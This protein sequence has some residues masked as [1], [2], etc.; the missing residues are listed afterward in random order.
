MEHE[1]PS[2]PPSGLSRRDLLT[3]S[4]AAVTLGGAPKSLAAPI[5]FDRSAKSAASLASD[6]AYWRSVARFYDRTE[7][8]VNLEQG[9]WAK[10][11]NPV[12]DT[13]F[14][15]LEMVNTQTSLY[16]RKDYNADMDKAVMAVADGLGAKPSEIAITENATESFHNLM[17]QY[18]GFEPGDGVLMA[19]IDYPAFKRF[20]RWQAVQNKGPLIEVIIPERANQDEVFQQYLNAFYA[21]PSLKL[22]LVTHVSNQHGL[23]VPVARIATEARKRGITVICDA[24]QSWGLLDFSISD[25]GVDFAAFNLHKWIGAPLGLGALYISESAID[26]IAPFHGDAP[27]ESRSIRARVHPATRNFAATLAIPKAFEF[28]EAVGPA[29][30]EARLKYLRNLWVAEARSMSHIELLGGTNP[31]SITGISSFRIRGKKTVSDAVSLQKRLE[32]EFGVFTVMRDGLNGGACVRITPQVFNTPNDI[33]VLVSAMG[34][35]A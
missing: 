16:A 33:E 31:A 21:N 11:A 4:V 18:R 14:Q 7:G 23:V 1:Q 3:A 22:M 29:A 20:M 30:K 13:Y 35:L 12:K 2:F 5:S 19:D 6:E 9:Y 24:A 10:M 27:E 15:A 17:R 8:I 28:H 32:A 34:K 26:A 25:L